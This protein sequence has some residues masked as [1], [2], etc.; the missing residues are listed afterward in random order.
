MSLSLGRPG[1][2]A[3]R[4]GC[5]D[6]HGLLIFGG[7]R[8]LQP[9]PVAHTPFSSSSDSAFQM[10]DPRGSEC[11][12]TLFLF[13]W[14]PHPLLPPPC[15]PTSWQALPQS[16]LVILVCL[17]ALLLPE[18]VVTCLLGSSGLVHMRKLLHY[19]LSGVCKGGKRP[20]SVQ[21]TA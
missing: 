10:V 4:M 16:V 9:W 7:L 1:C 11:S 15:L 6:I 14:P 17:I 20:L 19:H 8:V 13:Y 5:I 2:E 18:W 12:D 21:S 3:R